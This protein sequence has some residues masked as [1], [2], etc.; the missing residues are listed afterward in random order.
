MAT[1]NVNREDS[2][3]E[4][5]LRLEGTPGSVE[6]PGL[7]TY[8]RKLQPVESVSLVSVDIAAAE[9]LAEAIRA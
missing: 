3:N 7:D 4:V 1:L 9:E 2:G 6:T 8:K 5:T